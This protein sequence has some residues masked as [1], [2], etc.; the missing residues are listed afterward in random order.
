MQPYV[1]SRA[2]YRAWRRP[3]RIPVAVGR[4]GV[5]VDADPSK[6]E[7]LSEPRPSPDSQPGRGH[8]YPPGSSRA[9]GG[10]LESVQVS[11]PKAYPEP[12][13]SAWPASTGSAGLSEP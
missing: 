9:T 4:P 12:E 1:Q 3:R 10:A 13:L 2:P 5:S 11:H 6:P 7:T 8:T